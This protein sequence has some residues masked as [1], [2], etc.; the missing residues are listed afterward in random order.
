M[1][2]DKDIFYDYGEHRLTGASADKWRQSSFRGP[3]EMYIPGAQEKKEAP[4]QGGRKVVA[5][6]LRLTVNN[7]DLSTGYRL[8][9]AAFELK[10]SD[11]TSQKTVS[12]KAGQAVF[13]LSPSR[14]YVLREATP[15][16]GYRR[17]TAVYNVAVSS[18][19]AVKVNNTV[20]NKITVPSV[21]DGKPA[22]QAPPAPPTLPAE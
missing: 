1:G 6:A 9:G 13:M 19:G 22:P 11:G 17:N 18:S 3:S 4:S 10:C 14:A 2:K 8:S 16:K 21:G 7:I 15:P 12:D 20:T 5:T